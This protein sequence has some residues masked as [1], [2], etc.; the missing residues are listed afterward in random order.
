MESFSLLDVILNRPPQGAFVDMGF[1]IV[2]SW[3]LLLYPWLA[4][5]AV[6]LLTRIRVGFGLR[7]YFPIIVN[8][9]LV[10][11]HALWCWKMLTTKLIDPGDAR[12]AFLP[13]VAVLWPLFMASIVL[14]VWHLISCIRR[15]NR[16]RDIV[17]TAI[18]YAVLSYTL[19]SRA[20]NGYAM[21]GN[22]MSQ[23]AEN[24][25]NKAIERDAAS[26]RPSS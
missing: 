6:F 4:M 1:A 11:T 10:G 19:G 9:L 24:A 13:F 5:A 14:L 15:R 21:Y 2:R 16:W 25:S 8:L 17:I 18:C 23:I 26:R 7:N 12:S 3:Y 22:V 20:W